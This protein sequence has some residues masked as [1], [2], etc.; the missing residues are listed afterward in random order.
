[1]SIE[2]RSL[3][4]STLAREGRVGAQQWAFIDLSHLQKARLLIV[5]PSHGAQPPP[6]T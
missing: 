2:P 4:V 6:A 1:M 3:P 5:T